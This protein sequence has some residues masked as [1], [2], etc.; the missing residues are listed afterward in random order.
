MDI[1]QRLFSLKDEAYGDFTAA[2]IPTLERDRII[3]V[4]LPLLRQLGKEAMRA[5][6]AEEFTARL[7]HYYIEENFL[8]AFMISEIKNY[9]L[10]VRE[11]D[12]FL[13][14]V[15]NWSVCD[16]ISPK[17]FAAN[18][19]R[20][21]EDIRRMIASGETYTVRFALRM[22]MNH[23]LDVDFRPEYPELA[24]SAPCGEYYVDMMLAWYFA[25]ALAKQWDAALPYI[26]D[27]RLPDRVHAKAIQKAVE[28]RRISPERK[29]E[30][31][32]MRK[33]R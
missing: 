3:G 29:A 33:G 9:D 8:H 13:P 4:R 24:A 30:L 5:G 23:F 18:R 12:R 7:P 21:I 19:D 27:G 2:L 14:F 25:T 28:S 11:L 20:L 6:L 1:I 32:G 31:R 16:T 10:C 17:T 26:R 15:D 22:L